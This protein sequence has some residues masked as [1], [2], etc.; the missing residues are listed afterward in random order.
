MR[1]QTLQAT[2]AA[3]GCRRERGKSVTVTFVVMAGPAVPLAGT[4]RQEKHHFRELEKKC[5]EHVD[6]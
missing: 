5:F 4:R 2:A 1:R 6:F 3:G